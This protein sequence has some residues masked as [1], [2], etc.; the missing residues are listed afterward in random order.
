V[1]GIEMYSERRYLTVTGRRLDFTPPTVESRK[2]ELA[3]LHASLFGS[4]IDDRRGT[5]DDEAILR[6]AS[7]AGNGDKFRALWGGETGG[8]NSASEADAALCAILSFYTQDPA[9][10]E[11]L[12]NRSALN[13]GKW[14]ERPDYRQRTIHL[15]LGGLRET[16]GRAMASDGD[17]IRASAYIGDRPGAKRISCVEGAKMAEFAPTPIG[18][19]GKAGPGE[20]QPEVRWIGLP[21]SQLATKGANLDWLWGGYLAPRTITSLTA[22]WKSGK[23]TLLAHLL[24]ALDGGATE[25]CG[26]PVR[27]A[28]ALVVSEEGEELWATRRDEVGIGDHVSLICKPFL[29]RPEPAVWKDFVADLAGQVERNAYDLVVFDTLHNLWCVKKE[30]DAPQ[31][32]EALMPLNMLV[33]KGAAVLLNFHP[34][35]ADASEGRLTRGTGA[36]GG[37]MDVIVEMRRFDAGRRE[38]TRRVLTSYSRYEA[39]PAEVVIELDKVTRSYHAVGTRAA[40]S[41]G[42]RLIAILDMLPSGEPGLSVK[43]IFGMWPEPDGDRDDAGENRALPKPGLRTIQRDLEQAARDGLVRVTGAGNRNDPLR[44]YLEATPG[45]LE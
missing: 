9:Q 45:D 23:T 24:R 7:G 1:P 22:L 10:I 28:R 31:T 38:D 17:G 44:F 16:Y 34:T 21:I 43:E 11:R 15:A 20:A 19:A 41:A 32:I 25:F 37:F 42:D 13:R 40:A 3:A 29:G 30:E 5:L 18:G 33:E 26:Q 8:Y 39:T 2:E 4:R 14:S 6:L 36:T 12:F 27:R 35:K